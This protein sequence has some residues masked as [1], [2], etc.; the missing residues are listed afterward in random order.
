MAKRILDAAR[1]LAV[2]LNESWP[3]DVYAKIGKVISG[4]LKTVGL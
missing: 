3:S 1:R 4:Q 2:E